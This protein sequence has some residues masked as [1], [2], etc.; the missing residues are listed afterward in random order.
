MAK[1]AA[2]VT[3]LFSRRHQLFTLLFSRGHQL[4]NKRVRTASPSGLVVTKTILPKGTKPMLSK[5]KRT[6]IP[7]VV[8]CTAK[9]G[10]KWKRLKKALVLS[11]HFS[12]T[13]PFVKV[14]RRAMH[15]GCGLQKRQS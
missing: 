12:V 5:C 15:V 9:I 11:W 3:V 6:T 2:P 1:E 8:D 14:L 7:F 10:T 4:S 13:K